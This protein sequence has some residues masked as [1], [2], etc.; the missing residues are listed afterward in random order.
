VDE[1]AEQQL[2]AFHGKQ[3]TWTPGTI[4]APNDSVFKLAAAIRGNSLN[5]I[6]KVIRHVKNPEV[7]PATVPDLQYYCRVKRIHRF[8][9]WTRRA[10]GN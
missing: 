3:L 7:C 6:E 9:N 5:V 2:R 1:K 10:C 8:Q 4:D